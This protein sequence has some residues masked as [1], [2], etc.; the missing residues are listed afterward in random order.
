M[1]SLIKDELKLEISGPGPENPFAALNQANAEYESPLI[2]SEK[3]GGVFPYLNHDSY[4]T[5]S[6][7]K[8]VQAFILENQ[9]LRAII[10]PAT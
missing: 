9:L 2:K 3:R 5:E 1:P 7:P 6:Q 4:T 10:L 8:T